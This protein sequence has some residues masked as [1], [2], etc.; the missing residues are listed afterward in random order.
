MDNTQALQ[1]LLA[2]A[3]GHGRIIV[4]PDL[5][6][7]TIE[8]IAGLNERIAEGVELMTEGIRNV[9][10]RDAEIQRMRLELQAAKNERDLYKANMEDADRQSDVWG[11]RYEEEYE[12][13]LRLRSALVEIEEVLTDDTSSQA[14]QINRIIAAL[15]HQTEQPDTSPERQINFDP[16][17]IVIES[18]VRYHHHLK[19]VEWDPQPAPKGEEPNAGT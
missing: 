18:P 14:Q 11:K 16:D 17:N 6:Q 8:E 5:L 13:V 15:S 19:D 7:S 9:D 1:A 10:E 3:E 2:G 12:Q 4:S